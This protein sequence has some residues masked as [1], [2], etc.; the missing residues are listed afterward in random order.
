M[1]SLVHGVAKNRTR[2]SDFRFLTNCTNFPFGLLLS[3]ALLFPQRWVGWRTES[4][5]WQ[6]EA[7]EQRGGRAGGYA[8][9]AGCPRATGKALCVGFCPSGVLWSCL[10]LCEQTP[11][12]L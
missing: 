6:T 1:D 3:T 4:E 9:R 8:A 2:L 7:E 11:K 5:E 10:S 12:T